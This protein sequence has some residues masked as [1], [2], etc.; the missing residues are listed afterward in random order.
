M[1]ALEA[2]KDFENN[3]LMPW[4]GACL[5]PN[6]NNDN[7]LLFLSFFYALK[8]SAGLVELDKDKEHFRLAVEAVTLRRGLQERYP[9]SHLINSHDNHNGTAVG[10]ILLG[11]EDLPREWL[12]YGKRKCYIFDDH[13]P[14][15]SF[16]ESIIRFW[17]KRD[18]EPLQQ[19]S[20]VFLMQVAAGQVGWFT[21]LYYTASLLV[22]GWHFMTWSQIYALKQSKNLKG[23]KRRLVLWA[24][25]RFLKKQMAGR[26]IKEMIMDYFQHPNNPYINMAAYSKEPF[27]Y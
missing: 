4:G 25:K 10:Y 21:T 3:Y 8:Y 23:W 12:E 24:G 1:T 16:I 2:L 20:T 11:I 13:N 27:C 15:S 19:P 26:K 6:E 18:F 5:S 22:N 17:K 7:A 14:D 9:N